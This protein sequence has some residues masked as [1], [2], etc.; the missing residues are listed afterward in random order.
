MTTAQELERLR[1]TRGFSI[2]D[3]CNALNVDEKEYNRIIKHNRTPSVYQ[4]IMFIDLVH[5]PLE[6]I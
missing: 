2:I 3:V 4:L 1:Q 6:T 5:C